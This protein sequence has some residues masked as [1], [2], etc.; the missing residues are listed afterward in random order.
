M[1]DAIYYRWGN[2]KQG[3]RNLIKW[4]PVIWR[5]RD[6]DHAYLS[7]LIEFKLTSMY[8]FLN[9]DKAI[10]VHDR[11]ELANLVRAALAAHLLWR[12]PHWGREQDYVDALCEALRES[13]LSWWD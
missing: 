4:W 2:L 9:S 10:G 5:D 3:I 7:R 13:Y 6:W 12:R 11:H 1:F 8:M